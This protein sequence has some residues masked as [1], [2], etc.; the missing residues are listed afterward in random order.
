LKGE[1]PI[2]RQAVKAG[3]IHRPLDALERDVLSWRNVRYVD[4]GADSESA[5]AW[6]L[7]DRQSGRSGL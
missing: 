3:R 2:C 7:A 6:E 4:P 5:F 1:Y